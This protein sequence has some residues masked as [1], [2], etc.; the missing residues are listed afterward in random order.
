MKTQYGFCNITSI[1]LRANPS[2]KQEMVSQMLYGE[3]YKVLDA[4]GKW[5]L[6]RLEDD[7]YE[8]W[9]DKNQHTALAEEEYVTLK[10]M[11]KRVITKPISAINS[12][13]GK[14]HVSFGS[15][16][17]HT[18]TDNFAYCLNDSIPKDSI[19]F[20]TLFQKEKMISYAMGLLNVPYLWGGKTV[21][22]L[23]CSG[24]TQ[25][26]AK[27]AGYKLLR[28]AS[29]QATQ[30]IAVDFFQESIPGD[31][32]FFDNDEGKIIHVG[33]VIDQHK[34][35]HASGK[36]RVDTFDHQGIFDTEKNIYTHRLRLIKRL[37]LK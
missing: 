33:I 20:P 22:G 26:V 18:L 27:T 2:D 5:V 8:G 28:D 7:G 37:E 17:C 19:E 25:I 24:F 9:I 34:I 15:T 23:D 1:P 36:V 13:L 11:P 30:G 35:I 29:Q 14:I 3:V 12:K 31:L 16:F 4:Q 32:A 10:E 21:F 6:V